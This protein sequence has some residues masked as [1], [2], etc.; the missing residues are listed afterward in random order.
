MDIMAVWFGVGSRLAYVSS[1][2]GKTDIYTINT[3]GT[4]DAPLTNSTEAFG[5]PSWR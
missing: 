4:H 2:N 5:A 1:C 3:D